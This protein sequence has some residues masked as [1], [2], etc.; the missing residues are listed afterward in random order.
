M[1]RMLRTS[2]VPQ[3]VDAAAQV[4]YDHDDAGDDGDDDLA[5][6]SEV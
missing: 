5:R 4:A 1:G 3:P 2:M 6:G